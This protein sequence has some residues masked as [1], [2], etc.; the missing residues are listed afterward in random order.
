MSRA[1]FQALQNMIEKLEK[2]GFRE[3]TDEVK[4]SYDDQYFH[5]CTL[6]RP[7]SEQEKGPIYCDTV[8]DLY[9]LLEQVN[10]PVLEKQ[11]WFCEECQVVSCVNYRKRA[12]LLT[13]LVVINENHHYLSPGCSHSAIRVINSDIIVSR[14]A[15]NENSTIPDWARERLA[16]LLFES[17]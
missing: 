6:E 8:E 11:V 2:F 4:P 12:D 9:K 1:H 10:P 17:E 16:E 3:V 14:E 7:A 5:L 15:L 13:V